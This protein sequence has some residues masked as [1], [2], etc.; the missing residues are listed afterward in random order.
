MLEVD[1]EDFRNLVWSEVYKAKRQ[2]VFGSD[3]DIDDLFQ[4][5]SMV[6]CWCRNCWDPVKGS[7]TKFSYYLVFSIR[8]WFHTVGQTSLAKTRRGS[9]AALPIVPDREHPQLS[10]ENDLDIQE[11]L[12]SAAR[13]FLEVLFSPPD[14]LVDLY[15]RKERTGKSWST[16]IKPVICGFLGIDEKVFNSIKMELVQKVLWRE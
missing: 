10:F 15:R 14:E 16:Y 12:S 3:I 8:R 13:E 6:F 1:F 7:N 9:E 2:H 4:E 5:A 11:P